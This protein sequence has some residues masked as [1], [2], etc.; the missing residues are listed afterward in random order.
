[1]HILA[2]KNILNFLLHLLELPSQMSDAEQMESIPEVML[3][4]KA[5]ETLE[6]RKLKHTLKELL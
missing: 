1:L 2:K 3:F 4:T 6:K 5:N